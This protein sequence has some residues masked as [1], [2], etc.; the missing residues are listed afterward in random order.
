MRTTNPLE[1][2]TA[3]S[4]GARDVVGILPNYAVLLRL[5][6][7]LLIEQTTSGWSGRRYLVESSMALVIADS[8]HSHQSSPDRREVRPLGRDPDVTSGRYLSVSQGRWHGGV[9]W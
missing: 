7:M 1:R 2:S 3:R 9:A 8:G 5:A 4:G 6:G